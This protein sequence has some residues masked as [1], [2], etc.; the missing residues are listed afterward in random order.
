MGTWVGPG[1]N[2]VGVGDRYVTLFCLLLCVSQILC[3]RKF[4]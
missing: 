4:K 1:L 2:V 3:S